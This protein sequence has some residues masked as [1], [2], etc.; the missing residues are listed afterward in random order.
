MRKDID[1][2]PLVFPAARGLGVRA[3]VDIPVDDYGNVQPGVGGMSV[4]CRSP[5]SLPQHRRPSS[6]GGSGLDPVW[7]LG[8]TDLSAA[9]IFRLEEPPPDHGLIEPTWEMSFEDLQDALAETRDA[10]REV[11]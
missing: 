5:E 9:L 2:R 4:A 11:F 3:E 1:G 10:W 7:E 6:L 8:E